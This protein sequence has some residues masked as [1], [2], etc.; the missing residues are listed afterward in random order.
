MEQVEEKLSQFLPENSFL[1]V[2]KVEGH[3][4]KFWAQR[5]TEAGIPETRVEALQVAVSP[6]T[7]GPSHGAASQ[8]LER[9][10]I[11]TRMSMAARITPVDREAS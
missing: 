5:L 10:L 11:Y 9:Q 1:A 6:F 8:V 7:S 3:E 2:V 4:M